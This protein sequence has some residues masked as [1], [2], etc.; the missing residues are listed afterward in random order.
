M[1]DFVFAFTCIN[2]LEFFL[3]SEDPIIIVADATHKIIKD[4]SLKLFT[5][6]TF[7]NNL[8]RIPIIRILLGSDKEEHI[9]IALD[10][11]HTYAAKYNKIFHLSNI[12]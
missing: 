7:N 9:K 10:S 1:D 2:D 8:S 4:T 5:V 6:C 12:F 11:L 3:N